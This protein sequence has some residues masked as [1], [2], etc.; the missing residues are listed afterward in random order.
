MPNHFHL[1]IREKEIGG[2]SKFMQKLITG[3]TMYFNQ[4]NERSGSLFQGK[5]KASHIDN[6]RYLSYLISY[7]HLNPIK[8]IDPE[9]K[10]RGIRNKKSAEKFLDNYKYS[11]FVDYCGV[12]R[13]EKSILSMDTLPKYQ[14]TSDYFR[15]TVSDWLDY[16]SEV[17]PR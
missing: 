4:L 8:I 1:I 6:D 12:N 16:P 2:I 3:Y 15:A 17:E 7:V 9:W 10:E 14:D 11:S 13:Y 5:F